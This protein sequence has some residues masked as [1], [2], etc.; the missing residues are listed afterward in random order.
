[1][2]VKCRNLP[3][4][5]FLAPSISES[6]SWLISRQS[7]RFRRHHRSTQKTNTRYVTTDAT[8]PQ[9]NISGDRK[10]PFRP[11]KTR[12]DE[13]PQP[14]DD[15]A[16]LFSTG[17]PKSKQAKPSATEL[18]NQEL[19]KLL[20]FPNSAEYVRDEYRK[21]RLEPGEIARN[22][23]FPM[24]S[25]QQQKATADI[26]RQLRTTSPVNQAPRSTR[27]V[28]SRPSVGRTIELDPSKGLDF[29]RGL[30]LL[31]ATIAT[32]RV[33]GD[34]TKQRYHERPGLKRKRLKS[35]RWRRNFKKGFD[36]TVQRVKQMKA[37][38]W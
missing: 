21:S 5:P 3:I 10:T 11:L 38:G 9:R 29:A 18:I 34:R 37:Q 7:C 14:N 36:A 8:R 35:E 19:Q 25:T 33:R 1:M 2:I 30:N 28:R 4:L 24:A 12:L 23:K 6:S 31:G 27:T 26:Q 16:S 22:M 20:E 32:N 13:T 15:V 17:P